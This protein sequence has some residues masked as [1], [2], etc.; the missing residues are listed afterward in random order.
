MININVINESF[1][2]YNINEKY[3]NRCYE[4]LKAINSNERF[5]ESFEKIYKIL[6]IEDFKKV[7]ELWKINDIDILFSNS[8][9]P[10]VTN[11]MIL[12]GYEIHKRNMEKYKLDIHQI[13]IQKRRVKECFENDLTDRGY[14][15]VR[16]SQMLWSAY[17]IRGKI[18]EVGSL[19]FEYEDDSTIKI[20]IPKNTD[21]DIL[22][23][24]ESIEAS[25]TEL[26]KI[27]AM[28]SYEYI[29][30][31]WILSNQ[32]HSII[33]KNTNISKFYDLFEVT[34]GENCL[35]DILNFVFNIKKCDNYSN[36]DEKTS[37]QR[38]I[39]KELLNNSIFC[40]GMGILK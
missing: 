24:K 19:Q 9:N 14:N 6:Y 18:I 28:D 31:S 27:Y 37:L 26:K 34:D 3:K 25:K 13:N 10:F 8:I 39:K 33:D 21:F 2:F 11:L 5:I 38:I 17:F 30:D 12:S 1:E 40:L 15:A 36:L 23:V 20:H 4:A 35:E 22:K 7:K 29:C 16:I 32:L